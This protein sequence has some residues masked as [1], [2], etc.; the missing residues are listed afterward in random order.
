MLHFS[1]FHG[2]TL[3]TMRLTCFLVL[4]TK[5]K[6]SL[7]IR[8][9]ENKNTLHIEEFY[10]F[11]F[12]FFR[13]FLSHKLSSFLLLNRVSEMHYFYFGVF[14]SFSIY[15]QY[16]PNPS[17]LPLQWFPSQ[18]FIWSYSVV[19][20]TQTVIFLSYRPLQ[21]YPNWLPKFWFSRSQY[22]HDLGKVWIWSCHSSSGMPV[23]PHC[24]LGQVQIHW[25]D[26]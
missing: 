2:R 13:Y 15:I 9:C 8:S 23:S 7:A 19:S 22:C 3:S 12:F 4:K 20:L 16:K 17:I 25:C 26:A 11:F 24:L 10:I 5:L 18:C 1:L 6:Y 21:L 14:L